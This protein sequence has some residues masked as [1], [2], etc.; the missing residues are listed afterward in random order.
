MAIFILHKPHLSVKSPQELAP[1][2]VKEAVAGR[3]RT[4]SSATLDKI[5][6]LSYHD[7]GRLSIEKVGFSATY[8]NYKETDAMKSFLPMLLVFIAVFTLAPSVILLPFA[9]KS[10]ADYQDSDAEHQQ[11]TPTYRVLDITTGEVIEVPVRDYVIGAVCAEMPATF[12]EE[13]LKAQAV[14]SYTYAQRQCL[15]SR[16]DS[17]LC[18]ADFSNDSARF[19]AYYTLSQIRTFYGDGFDIYYPKVEA[20]VDAVLG[21]YLS[22]EDQPIIAAFHSMSSGQTESAQTVWGSEVPYLISVPSESD[23]AAPR[24]LESVTFTADELC[25]AFSPYDASIRFDSD[26]DNWIEVESATAS[27][28]VTECRIGDLTVDGQTVRTALGLRSAAFTVKQEGEEFTF[29]TR[30]YGHGVGMSQYGAN[31]MAAAGYSFSDILAHYYPG[32]ILK[33]SF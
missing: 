28:T 25:K 23:E 31:E 24:Y 11:E 19:Q 3:H 32:T 21:T 26:D 14:A 15:S 16:G 20:A 27:G 13:A 29:S 6:L 10:S 33:S 8:K 7:T 17:S 22:Y 9:Q 12:E 5:L 1:F 2:P 4:S 30:G 18:G